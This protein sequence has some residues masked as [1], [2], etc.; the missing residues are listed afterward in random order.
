VKT[1][2]LLSGLLLAV[3]VTLS[4]CHAMLVDTPSPKSLPVTMGIVDTNSPNLVAYLSAARTINSTMNPTPYAPAI[5]GLLTGLVTL[6]SAFAGWYAR[7]ATA[8]ATSDAVLSA[9]RQTTNLILAQK[10]VP[11]APPV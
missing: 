11:P 4:A 2:L 8:K 3:V 9:T 5:D 10:Q 1:K 7:H 6:A